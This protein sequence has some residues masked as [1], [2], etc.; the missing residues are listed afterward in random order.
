MSEVTVPF[1]AQLIARDNVRP[2]LD[3]VTAIVRVT[4]TVDWSML[5]TKWAF[6]A[7]DQSGAVYVYTDKPIK[8]TSGWQM[9]TGEALLIHPPYTRRWAETLKRRDDRQEDQGR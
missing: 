4:F 3:D 6:A 2:L 1:T 5:A 7:M 9:L 8:I